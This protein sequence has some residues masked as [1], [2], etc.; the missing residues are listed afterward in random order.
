MRRGL[1]TNSMCRIVGVDEIPKL[2]DIKDVP[3]ESPVE[4]FKYCMELQS[5]C[6][7]E[8]GVGISAVQVGKPW[9]LFLVKGDG[10]N[11]YLPKGEYG[12]F[13]NCDYEPV[14]EE[15]VVSVEGCLSIP[16]KD[17]KMRLFK[18]ERNK[19]IKV[20]GLRL[21]A[22]TKFEFLNFNIELDVKEQAVVFQHEIDHHRAVL[23]SDIGE[24]IF[25][26]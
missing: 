15:T 17:G 21:V 8:N 2:E 6:E 19:R 18:V 5:L 10:T 26:W 7:S 24:E 23:I 1:K 16:P 22:R 20:S 4:L 3:I 25:F 12:Y 13:I 11:P 14:G 9:K